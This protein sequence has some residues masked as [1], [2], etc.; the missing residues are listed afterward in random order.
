[1]LF[2]L[3]RLVISLLIYSPDF[4]WSG[5]ESFWDFFSVLEVDLIWV[6]AGATLIQFDSDWWNMDSSWFRLI[7]VG[8]K[9]IW[10][11]F[12]LICDWFELDWSWLRLIWVGLKLIKIDLWL[13]E[14]DL[15]LF[16]FR[17]EVDLD[18]FELDWSWFEVDSIWF[19]MMKHA[20]HWG[21][22]DF[23]LTLYYYWSDLNRTTYV[24]S[25]IKIELNPI[26]FRFILCELC[27]GW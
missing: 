9:L 18:W 3:V 27:S 23:D 4:Y 2:C 12:R 14:F 24:L 13:I 7:C 17:I 15:D 11:W 22:F 21:W 10:S 1:V 16:R 25:C 20:L 5:V 8:L 26:E 19:G 6:G